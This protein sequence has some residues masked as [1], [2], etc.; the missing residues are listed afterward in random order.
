MGAPKLENL[1]HY[2]YHEYV[3][4]DGD[5][6]LIDGVPYS[7]APAPMT[8]HQDISQNIAGQ[9]YNLLVDCES[10]RALLPV[11]WK[12]DEDTV[13][14]PDNLIVCEEPGGAYITKAPLMIFEILSK[15][16]VFRDTQ[17]K[18]EIYQR[19]GVR[20]YCIVNPDD[21]IAKVYELKEG[22]YIKMADV[23]EESLDFDLGFCSFTFDFSRI[24]G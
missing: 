5:W 7:M 4:W 2:T 21:R 14:Q 6:E 3:T 18:F 9:L 23:I 19:E 11:D 1:P 8:S 22:R 13:V 10:C 15:S 17:V 12:I 24:W 20:Y 16:S